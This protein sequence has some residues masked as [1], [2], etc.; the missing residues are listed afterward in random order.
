MEARR[1]GELLAR[2]RARRSRFHLSENDRTRMWAIYE[3]ALAGQDRA[4][5]QFVDALKKA[6]L[7]N[8]T[9]FV[10][11]GDVSTAGESRGP[12]GDGEDLTEQLLRVPL[13]VHFPGSALSG[14]RVVVPTTVTDIARSVLAAL[15]LTTPDE[16]EG[17]D[18]FS[19]ASGEAL[20]AGRPLV[21][22]LGQRY[23]LRL[24]DLVLSGTSGRAP[25]LCEQSVDPNCEVD[26]MDKMPRAS[27]LLFRLAF[28]AE[29]AAQKHK[30]PR[31]P[32]T[33][34]PNTAAAIQVWGE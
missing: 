22:T 25:T 1:A 9:L 19:L 16:F 7:W 27:A 29:M 33:V 12:F 13:W 21:A 28:E 3:G 2:A 15:R 10:V 4:L 18:L 14:K 17:L 23:S 6:N 34:D 26:R 32:A 30:H 11:T 20:P 8:E 31:E 24:G 5:G